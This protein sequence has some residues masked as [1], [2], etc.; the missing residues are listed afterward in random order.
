MSEELDL[1]KLTIEELETALN[2]KK[3]AEAQAKEK[4]MEEFAESIA[5]EA[6]ENNYSGTKDQFLAILKG[7]VTKASTGKRTSNFRYRDDN[8]KEYM[9]P[10]RAA[11][12]KW[13]E[14]Q[15]EK[16]RQNYEDKHGK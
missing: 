11:A 7:V 12:D 9:R 2:K 13:S 1:S 4:A 5:N 8:G 16:Y 3:A 14:A 6:S 10:P 15:T